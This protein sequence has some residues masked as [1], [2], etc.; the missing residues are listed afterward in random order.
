MNHTLK[1]TLKFLIIFFQLVIHLG[2]EQ[3]RTKEHQQ[4][5]PPYKKTIS[6]AQFS[7]STIIHLAQKVLMQSFHVKYKA[8]MSKMKIQLSNLI[9]ASFGDILILINFVIINIFK[10]D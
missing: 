3:K 2:V 4:K 9:Y 8:E 5:E 6:E 10:I 7:I 1:S